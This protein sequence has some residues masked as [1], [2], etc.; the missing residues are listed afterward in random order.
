MIVTKIQIVTAF[1]VEPQILLSCGQNLQN[2]QK[3]LSGNL[4]TL[5]VSEDAPPDAPRALINSKDTLINIGLDRFE[6]LIKPPLHISGKYET[7]LE[8]AH[9]RMESIL[10]ILF[11]KLSIKYKWAGCVMH[12]HYPVDKSIKRAIQIV[13]P[14]YDKLVNFPREEKELASFDLRFGFNDNN[15]FKTYSITGYEKRDIKLE[16]PAELSSVLY[17]E[18]NEFPV[19]ESGIQFSV[20]INNKIRRENKSPIDDLLEILVESTATFT[21]IEKKLDLEGTI[22]CQI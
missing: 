21:T 10:N 13:T 20:D 12:I 16:V 7:C 19:I 9:S 1:Q 15:F 11:H 18:T 6:I 14:V 8:F 2:I 5:N 3:L 4:M 17:I 22:K